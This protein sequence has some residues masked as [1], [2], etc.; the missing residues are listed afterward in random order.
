MQ[1]NKRKK[2]KVQ[3]VVVLHKLR[4]KCVGKSTLVMVG[5]LQDWSFLRQVQMERF[6]EDQNRVFIPA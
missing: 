1:P 4:Y 2:A 5:Q 3:N 6:W